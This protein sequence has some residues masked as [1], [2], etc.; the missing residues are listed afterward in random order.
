MRRKR[1]CRICRRWFLPHP[2]AGDRQR[3]CSGASCQR[4]RNRRSSAAW[5]ARN[6]EEERADRL[7]ARLVKQGEAEPAKV[8]LEDPRLRIDFG[9]A[10]TAVGLEATVFVEETAGVL[11]WWARNAVLQ[12]G[13]GIT[14]KSP[15]HP[16]VGG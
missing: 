12:Q 16:G 6:G 8:G 4:E 5:R 13:T 3:V 15:K 14:G 2:R 7:R 10:R 1:P 9:A 11:W